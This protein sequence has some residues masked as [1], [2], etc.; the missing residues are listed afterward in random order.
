MRKMKWVMFGVFFTFCDGTAIERHLDPIAINRKA[1]A[2]KVMIDRHTYIAMGIS[3]AVGLH[4]TY[5]LLP[6][7]RPI[8][9]TVKEFFGCGRGSLVEPAM[10]NVPYEHIGFF[11]GVAKGF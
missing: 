3:V 2:I 1:G 7:L 4:Q 11:A 6:T 10:Q 9:G 8:L 5:F